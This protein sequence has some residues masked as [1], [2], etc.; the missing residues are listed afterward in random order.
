M[1]RLTQIGR[2]AIEAE[3]G[4]GAMGSVYRARDPMM[5]RTVAIKTILATA[6]TGP[7]A[8]E[9]RERF[10]REARAA[11]RLSHPGIVT[12]YDVGEFES[13]PFLVMEFIPGRTLA[14]AL[15]AG[16]RFPFDR[17]YEIGQQLA[18]ALGFAHA[19]GVIHRDIKPANILLTTPAGQSAERAKIA[20]FGVA[21]L[22]ATQMTA[23]G[24]LMGTPSFMPPEQFTGAPIDGRSDIFSLGV[25]LYSLATGDKPFPGDTLTA[26]SYKVVHTQPLAPRLINPA[27]PPDLDRVILKCLEKDPARRYATGEELARDLSN[28]RAGLAPVHAKLGAPVKPVDL[29]ATAD[30][31][32]TAHGRSR[33]LPPPAAVAPQ[34]TTI[35]PHVLAQNVAPFSHKLLYTVAALIALIVITYGILEYRNAGRAR[36]QAQGSAPATPPSEGHKAKDTARKSPPPAPKAAAGVKEGA[37]SPSPPDSPPPSPAAAAL[38]AIQI[39]PQIHAQIEEARRLA[40]A[41]GRAAS[42]THLQDGRLFTYRMTDS[43]ARP[44]PPG[45]VRLRVDATQIPMNISFEIFTGGQRVMRARPGQGLMHPLYEN[46]FAKPGEQQVHMVFSAGASVFAESSKLPAN[47]QEGFDYTMALVLKG[48]SLEASI[49]SGTPATIPT[50]QRAVEVRPLPTGSIAK[51]QIETVTVPSGLAFLIYMDGEVFHRATGHS[52]DATA[53]LHDIPAGTHDFRAYLTAGRARIRGSNA[54]RAEFKPGEKRK[55]KIEFADTPASEGQGPRRP[56]SGPLKLTLE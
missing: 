53:V 5:D 4:H 42:L 49:N 47:F 37:K 54:L 25:I 8:E 33:P 41:A 7:L 35:A 17:I 23:T 11:G 26:V 38:D 29:E 27:V 12:V 3:L 18:E 44:V 46:V 15:D 39:P 1:Q 56:D 52:A 22:T 24:Q 48:R 14:S 20:D 43:I 10:L 51:L 34:P 28:L 2:Y 19:S 36:Q 16:E 50:P 55:L 45:R 9:Y 6:L 31:D 21:K 13:T 30:L 32:V 40:E